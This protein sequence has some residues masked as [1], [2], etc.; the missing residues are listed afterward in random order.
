MAIIIPA[1]TDSWRN[2][3]FSLDDKC[4]ICVKTYFCPQCV[5][6]QAQSDYDGSD[7]CFNCLCVNN[8]AA[9][10]ATFRHGYG[11]DGSCISDILTACC[12]GLCTI[13]QL[14]REAQIRGRIQNL[15]GRTVQSDWSNPFIDIGMECL[16]ALFFGMCSAASARTEFD[17]S[18]WCFNC[19]CVHPLYHLSVI[20]NG[21]NIAG[22]CCGDMITMHFFPC[23]VIGRM[24]KETAKRGPC[25]AKPGQAAPAAVQMK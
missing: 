6:A 5:L 4:G 2:D 9:V 21:Y 10:R 20:R 15:T 1:P 22:G 8:P 19:C 11:I 16:I 7:C 24:R 17:G 18:N 12:C 13:A 3:L 25:V 14:S 23:C